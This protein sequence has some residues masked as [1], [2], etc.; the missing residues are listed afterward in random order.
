MKVWAHHGDKGTGSSSPGRSL[1]EVAINP[2]IEPIEPRAGWPQVKTPTGR[3]YNP[4]H[5]QI[6]GLKLY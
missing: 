6:V 4:T 5:Q 3:E 2:T 1:L